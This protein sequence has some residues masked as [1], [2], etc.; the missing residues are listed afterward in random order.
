MRLNIARL[1][2]GTRSITRKAVRDST[3]RTRLS[4]IA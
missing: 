1:N 4:M 2:A 3:D